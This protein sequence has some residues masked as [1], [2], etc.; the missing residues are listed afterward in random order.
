MSVRPDLDVDLKCQRLGW[1]EIAMCLGAHEVFNYPCNLS[2]AK[3]C[4]LAGHGE[5]NNGLRKIRQALESVG[6]PTC[7]N[8]H[9]NHEDVVHRQLKY[10]D[11]LNAN[12]HDAFQTAQ[13]RQK[14]QNAL[15][16]GQ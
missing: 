2:A 13:D 15:C 9:G 16:V 5:P 11:D 14:V 7:P 8:P 1:R 6:D 12:L 3:C 4:P 10:M